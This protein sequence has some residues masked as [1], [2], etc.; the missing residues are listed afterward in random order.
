VRQVLDDARSKAA[1]MKTAHRK[2]GGNPMMRQNNPLKRVAG[3]QIKACYLTRS[4]E[5][6]THGRSEQI[7]GPIHIY[8]F[9][10]T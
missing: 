8:G 4:R 6:R 5:R 3:K 2:S 1:I 7:T 9:H 10:A